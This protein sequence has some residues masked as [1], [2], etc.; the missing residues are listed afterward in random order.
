M[1]PPLF[2]RLLG[3][4][5]L[6]LALLAPARAADELKVAEGDH[7]ARSFRFDSGETLA[8]LR[9][10]YRTVGRPQR[11]A[12][13]RV[14]NAVLVM[15]G[16]GGSGAQFIRPEFSG[17]LFKA[18]GV[19]DAGRYYIVLPDAIGHGG[20]SKPSDGLRAGFPRYGY[21]DMVRAQHLLLSEGLKIDHLRLVWA[22]R[23][24]ACRPGCGARATLTSWMR[25]SR[26][27]ACPRRSRAATA[28][29]AA[30]SSTRSARTRPG[31]AATTSSSRPA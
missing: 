21:E 25:C 16:T 29:G 19:L 6:G 7:I 9:L 20:S 1:H 12:Q 24:A 18:G 23:W 31:R 5:L 26:W 15:H 27:P 11:D 30:S 13:G 4:L 3:G 22:P 28:S 17:E 2:A 10:H 14:T 8:E